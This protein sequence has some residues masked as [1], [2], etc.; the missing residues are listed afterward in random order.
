[1]AG[2]FRHYD[3][4]FSAC[5]RLLAPDGT[6]LLQTI[7]LPEQE[8]AAYRKRVDWI[9]TYIFPGSEL[10]SLGAIQRSLA[11]RT[12]LALAHAETFGMHYAK[13]LAAWRERF[14]ARLD[15]VRRLR[16]DE[17]FE[18]MWNFYLVWC[19]GAFRERYINVAQLLF[20]K[21]GLE[22][23]LLGDPQGFASSIRSDSF[24]F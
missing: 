9:Q 24:S 19:E 17:R 23:T 1:E 22:G 10:A 13:T 3:E 5:D 7:T 4:F 21:L 11:R 20:A 15:A 6:M 8:V 14:V 16:F 18:R 2:G 12:V